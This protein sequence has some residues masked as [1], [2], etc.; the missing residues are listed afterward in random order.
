[1]FVDPVGCAVFNF[2]CGD[3]STRIESKLLKVLEKC[4]K[5]ADNK[6]PKTQEY[7]DIPLALPPLSLFASSS[8]PPPPPMSVPDISAERK[9]FVDRVSSVFDHARKCGGLLP[10][11]KLL[12]DYDPLEFWTSSMRQDFPYHFQG[13]LVAMSFCQASIYQESVLV[14][15]LPNADF[16]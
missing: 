6:A 3:D 14:I 10:V 8:F 15:L 1:M 12:G 13:N 16:V 9:R 4:S 5:I 2:V 7:D 11:L